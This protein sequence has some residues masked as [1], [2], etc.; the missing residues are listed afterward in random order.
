MSS[1]TSP[2]VSNPTNKVGSTIVLKSL[3]ILLGLFFIFIGAMKIS[4]YL[5]KELHKDLRKEYVKYAKVFPLSSI[6]DFKIP[7]KWYRRVVGALEVVCGLAMA[8]IPS[9]KIKNAANI[10]LLLLMFLAVY[11]HYMV[12][13]PFERSGPALVFTFMLCGRLV[14]WYQTSKREA[15]MAEAAQIQANGGVKQ[16]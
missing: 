16:D 5:S 12:S 15:E 9:H 10:S 13:D 8:L 11:S 3:S 7:S 14:V 1:S 6:F 4:P 2:L